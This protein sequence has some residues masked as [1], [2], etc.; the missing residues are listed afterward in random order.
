ML[1]FSE[2]NLNL[3]ISRLLPAW[4]KF[5][6]KEFLL[7]DVSA[8]ITVAF[9]AIPLSLAIALAS[10]VSPGVGLVTAIVAGIVCALFGGTPLSVSGPAAAM[11]IVIADIVQKFGL[12][13]LVLI[14]AL[15]G[16]M[17]L[18]SGM[19][20]LGRFARYVPLPVIAGFT[21]GIGAIILIGQL[22]RAFGLMPPAESDIFSVFTHLRQY[23]HEIDGACVLLVVLTLG[24][25]IGLPKLFPRIPSIL[26]AVVI[27]SLLA[28]IFDLSDVPLIG[29]IPASLPRPHFPQIPNIS[30]QDLVFNTF[31]IYL[32]ASLETLLSSSAIDKLSKGE[33]HDSNQELIGQGLGNIAV[34]LFGG[35][36]VTSVIARSATNVR[37]GAKT[38]RASIIHSFI[39]LLTIFIAAP[40]ISHIP[41]A[42]LAGVLF[43]VAF[44][45]VNYREFFGLWKTARPDALIYAITFGTIVFVD[46]LAGVQAGI[47]AA[48]VLVLMR[49]TKTHFHV[50]VNSEDDMVRLSL[51]GALTFLSTPKISDLQKQLATTRANQIVLMDLSNIRN[52]DMSGAD[53][54]VQL[55]QDCQSKHINF[56]IKGL[57]RRFESLFDLCGGSTLLK[58]WYVVSEHELRNKAGNNAP[59]SAYG[60]LVHGF[61]RFYVQR[62]HDDKRLFESI[63]YKQDPHTLFIACSDSRIIPSMITSA[64]PGELFIVRN[65]GNFIPPYSENL[66]CSEAAAIEFALNSFDITDIVV[67]GH[68]NCGAMSAC[69]AFDGTDSLPQVRAWINKIRSQLV[70][71]NH[72]H[73][74]ELAQKN[75][76]NQV[77]NLRLYP[78]VLEKIRNNNLRMHAWFYDFEKSLVYEWSPDEM[79]FTPIVQEAMPQGN[80]LGNIFASQTNQ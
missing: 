44:S 25:I 35:I 55:F 24:F 16:V 46:L 59:K 43:F 54:I 53:A 60:R 5:F 79:K 76:L 50:S 68:A 19:F 66:I 27:V 67:C 9:I 8:G 51:V 47:M 58:E 29:A 6:S 77:S 69:K 3:G 38:R 62:Q 22:P 26:P 56:Y 64:D 74:N 42:V 11:S 1:N 70:I 61:Q 13:S 78:I 75:V 28:Y 36:P 41:I 65:I 45:M 18:L 37:A 21:A 12:E 34:S 39:L 4:R 7:E 17:Q 10:G 52:L 31:V 57:P 73:L 32:L 49:A 20:N 23:L 80:V 71:N 48:C 30:M 40:L 72:S 2:L 15:A 63:S 14:C 33:K